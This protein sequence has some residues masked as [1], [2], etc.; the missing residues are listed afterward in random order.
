MAKNKY[1]SKK[2][3]AKWLE[4]WVDEVGPDVQVGTTRVIDQCP[5]ATYLTFLTNRTWHAS[6][7]ACV[8]LVRAEVGDH[9]FKTP[10]WAKEYIY[11]LD[12][13]YGRNPHLITGEEALYILREYA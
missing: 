9:E 12:R 10:K 3:F 4:D 11:N 6:A 8:P 2:G 5:I 13:H 1:L 7:L